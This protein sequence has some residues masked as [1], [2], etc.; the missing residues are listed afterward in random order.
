MTS[1]WTSHPDDAHALILFPCMIVA[2]TLGLLL[3]FMICCWERKHQRFFFLTISPLIGCTCMLAWF[4][5]YK[6]SL[7]VGISILGLHL[8]KLLPASCEASMPIEDPEGDPREIVRFHKFM[9]AVFNNSA[10]L[11]DLEPSWIVTVVMTSLIYGIALVLS[12]RIWKDNQHKIQKL[13]A[14]DVAEDTHDLGKLSSGYAS[15]GATTC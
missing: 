10:S 9:S 1:Y 12:F 11:A 3:G 5:L 15:K 2:S 14:S 4:L 13:R 6:Y 7:Y 8:G